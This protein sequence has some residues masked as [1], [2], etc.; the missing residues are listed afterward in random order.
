[1]TERGEPLGESIKL[2]RAPA[3]GAPV[4]ELR[5]YLGRAYGLP[6]GYEV[7]RVVRHGG[8]SGTALHV[9]LHAPGGKELVI[10]YEEERLCRSA[11]SLRAQAAADT[12]GLTRGDLLTS[13]AAPAVFEALC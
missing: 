5:A 11:D 6:D 2:G 8:R 13:R 9:H 1:M 12:D 7:R 4:G 10:A 3:H